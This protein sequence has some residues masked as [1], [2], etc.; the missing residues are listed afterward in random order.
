MYAIQNYKTKKFVFGTDRR[1]FP[2]IQR[3]SHE[4]MLTYEDI[5]EALVDF[6]NRRCGG[7]YEIVHI[8]AIAHKLSPREQDK[9][10][11]I[12]MKTAKWA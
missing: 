9:V 10:A 8:D 12:M 2:P 1:R 6:Q 11:S 5:E 3:T 7:S 4:K